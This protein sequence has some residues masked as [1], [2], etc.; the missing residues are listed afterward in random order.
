MR[1]NKDKVIEE[2]GLK[3]FGAKGW[4]SSDE[5][6]CPVCGRKDKFGIL[7]TPTGG[8]TH[9]FYNC[10]DNMS[11]GKYLRH[12]K[13][14][15][16]ILYEREV[17]IGIKLPTIEIEEVEEEELPEVKLP[18]GYIRTYFD[19]YLNTRNFR[20][21]QYEQFEVG[22]TTHFLEKKLHN[23]LIFVLKQQ[24]RAVGWLARSKYS[25]EWHKEN[26]ENFKLGLCPLVLRYKNSTGTDFERIIG[27]YDEIT[28]NTHTVIAVEGLF[29]K[30]NISNLL[31]TNLSEELKVIFTIGDSFTTSQI[32]LLK[33][34]KV[35]RVILMYDPNTTEQSMRYSME[36]SR[37]FDVDVCCIEDE[38]IDPGNM[39]ENYLNELLLKYK[40][41]MYFYT[42]KIPKS[43]KL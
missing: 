30:T 1:I 9:C 35:R 34:T 36:L 29:D 39:T 25:K 19:K 18:K 5:T 4:M 13:R 41:F 21:Y 33:Q 2:L 27:G 38:G 6:A 42:S 7:F 28:D 32:K 11:L 31:K 40:N 43:L 26:L 16:L 23:Y 3:Y 22:T 20:S 17:S 8:V 15:D 10:S 24:G 37:H 12:I 14:E